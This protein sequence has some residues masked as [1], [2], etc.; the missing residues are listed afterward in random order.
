MSNLLQIETG[1]ECSDE[2]YQHHPD[3]STIYLCLSPYQ[4]ATIDANK[5]Y[6]YATPEY[7]DMSHSLMQRYNPLH[8][9]APQNHY[10][11]QPTINRMFL[12]QLHIWWRP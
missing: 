1:T 9:D 6:W 5:E 8:P 12:N 3:A 10:Y 11:R 4:L 7:L 2:Q